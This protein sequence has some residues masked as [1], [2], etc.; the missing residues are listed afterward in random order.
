MECAFCLLHVCAPVAERWRML[1]LLAVRFVLLLLGNGCIW[2]YFLIGA[3]TGRG[4]TGHGGNEIAVS[5]VEEAVALS[6]AATTV[7]KM[8]SAAKEGASLG[9]E[10]VEV[11]GRVLL[12]LPSRLD[13]ACTCATNSGRSYHT[14]A[15]V[16]SES[17]NSCSVSAERTLWHRNRMGGVGETLGTLGAASLFEEGGAGAGFLC[18]HLRMEHERCGALSLQ[19]QQQ[20]ASLCGSPLSRTWKRS[21]MEESS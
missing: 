3:A 21:Q 8:E 14:C 13:S 17:R 4:G 12:L 7:K 10:E 18:L 9:G 5:L 11:A 1:L 15:K 16:E 19:W 2:C 6:L 20:V